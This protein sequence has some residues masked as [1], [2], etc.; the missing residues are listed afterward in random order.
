[1][2][3]RTGV[4]E[5]E[6]PSVSQFTFRE[7]QRT[8]AKVTNTYKFNGFII[9]TRSQLTQQIYFSASYGHL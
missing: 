3:L 4:L 8:E 7:L 9:G 2:Y 6:L 5:Q 1:M